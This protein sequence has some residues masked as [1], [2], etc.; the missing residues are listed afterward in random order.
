MLGLDKYK[1]DMRT[2]MKHSTWEI[3]IAVQEILSLAAET[4]TKKDV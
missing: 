1:M 4:P 3:Q 2:N